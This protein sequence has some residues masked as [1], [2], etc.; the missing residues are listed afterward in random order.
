VKNG[1]DCV[2]LLLAVASDV[3]YDEA[4]S[5]DPVSYS[6]RPDG[7]TLTSILR[8]SLVPVQEVREGNV[9]AF[10]IDVSD[11]PTHVAII[12]KHPSIEGEFSLIHSHARVRKV[13]EV[14]FDS[15]WRS[16]VAET[17]AFPGTKD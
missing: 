4:P 9:V 16:R 7:V 2:G 10:W 12:G 5:F 6:R 1:L 15:Y 13:V 8:A 14:T 17:Y 11:R 3:G